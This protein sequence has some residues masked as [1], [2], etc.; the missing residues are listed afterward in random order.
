M[1][2]GEER[3]DRDFDEFIPLDTLGNTLP[4]TSFGVESIKLSINKFE[5]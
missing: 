1:P 5:K 4:D 3:L 2:P